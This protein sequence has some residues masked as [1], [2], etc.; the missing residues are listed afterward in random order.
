ST[1]RR[2]SIR[3]WIP[4]RKA[5][6]RVTTTK[7]TFRG[8]TWPSARWP[9]RWNG[10]WRTAGAVPSR[11]TIT[12]SSR[13]ADLEAA[14]ATAR[15]AVSA[16]RTRTVRPG[17]PAGGRR[18]SVY[19]AP[20]GRLLPGHFPLVQRRRAASLVEPR[21]AHGAGLRRLRSFAFAAQTAAQDRA[22]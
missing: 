6:K 13:I 4:A 10:S 20:D 12:R 2:R 11:R 9:P 1:W 15:Y 22:R 19:R 21:S 18:R 5:W 17:G 16:G 7:P 14:L 8:T 3:V